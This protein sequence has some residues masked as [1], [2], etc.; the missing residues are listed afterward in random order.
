MENDRTFNWAGAIYDENWNITGFYDNETDNYLQDHYQLHLSQ[1]ISDRWYFNSA[2]HYTYGQGYYEQ[3]YSNEYL[4]DYP[5]GIQYFD[6]DSIFTAGSY[7]Y[8]YHDTISYG[9]MIVRRWL[10]NHFYGTTYAFHYQSSSLQLTLGGAINQYANAKHFGE[11]IWT[12]YAGNTTEGDKF[13]NNSSDKSDFTLYSKLDYSL[14]NRVSFFVDLQTRNVSYKGKGTDKGAYTVNINENYFFLNP[15]AGITCLL[16]KFGTFYASYAVSNREPIR[17]DFLDAPEG[18]IP[19]P[20]KLQNIEMGLRNKRTNLN[21]SIN[22]YLMFYTNQL[23]LTG[24]IND[25]G[26]PVRANTG[27]SYRLGLECDVSMALTHYLSARTNI[28]ISR[29]R[30]D[31]KQVEGEEIVTY[32]EVPLTFSPALI[33]GMEVT[34]IPCK[35]FEISLNGKYVDRQYLDLT[36]NNE[37]SIDPYFINNLR[38]AWSIKAKSLGECRLSLQINNLFNVQYASNGYV[39]ENVPYFYPQAGIHVIGGI[40]LLF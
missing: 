16:N 5:I 32:T 1:N 19:K 18:V 4:G 26:Y 3:Y 21:Y 40:D 24:E 12:E 8:Y 33:G 38:L 35:S 39:W 25:V 9:D 31:Y 28:A 22:G 17:T 29:N 30:T 13:Y 2:L 6:Y 7:Q 20:E 11:I 14:T 23:V 15:K 36:G 27:S 37:R 10:D 34:V